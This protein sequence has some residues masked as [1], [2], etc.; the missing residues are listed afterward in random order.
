[1]QK[2]V[3]ADVLKAIRVAGVFQ[4]QVQEALG[5]SLAT[6]YKRLRKELSPGEKARWLEI[7]EQ[8]AVG[9]DN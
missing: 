1:M 8:L 6:F 2:K 5:I 7:V 9:N 4:Y 3:N